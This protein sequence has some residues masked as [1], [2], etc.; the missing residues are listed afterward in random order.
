MSSE[1]WQKSLKSVYE[2][3]QYML[4]SK[5]LSDIIFIFEKSDDDCN[6]I[7]A[8][9]FELAKGS[10]VFEKLFYGGEKDDV[11][12][13]V[14]KDFSRKSFN[15]MIKFLYLDEIDV[16]PENALDILKLSRTYEIDGLEINYS[17]FIT[18]YLNVDNLSK[19]L[20]DSLLLKTDLVRNK[21]IKFIEE[22][23]TEIFQHPSLKNISKESLTVILNSNS[24]G[25]DT[26][27]MDFFNFAMEWAKNQCVKMGIDGNAK[28]IRNVLGEIFYL[29][30]FPSMENDDFVKCLQDDQLFTIEEIGQI[31]LYINLKKKRGIKFNFQKKEKQIECLELDTIIFENYDR[32]L[33]GR[34]IFVLKFSVNN[35]ISL[36]RFDTMLESIASDFTITDDL[37]QVI[38]TSRINDGY[39]M[40]PSPIDFQPNVV[41]EIK[42]QINDSVWAYFVR[43]MEATVGDIIVKTIENPSHPWNII[44]EMHFKNF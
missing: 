43:N 15:E 13:I 24:K 12:E 33:V 32:T 22:N 35:W 21:C 3:N 7:N 39:Y 11:K 34:E 40:F 8:H 2:R 27:V 9:K 37:N 23:A 18:K 14:I 6:S 5:K 20:D 42:F 44:T 28:N 17:D 26:S 38:Y 10:A 30:C 16:N 41:Y 29:I 1:N 4:Q 36:Y 25:C 31:F 19:I